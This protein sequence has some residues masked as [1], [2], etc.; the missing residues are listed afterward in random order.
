M[1][2]DADISPVGSSALQIFITESNVTG[3][4]KCDIADD[5]DERS[6]DGYDR[7]ATSNVHLFSTCP[8][9]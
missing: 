7:K 8:V 2:W 9:H 4:M 5:S 6:R 3:R 1:V